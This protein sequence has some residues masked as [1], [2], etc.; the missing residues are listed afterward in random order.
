MDKKGVIKW[1]IATIIGGIFFVGS[2]AWEWSH[3]IH[4]SHYGSVE[5]ASGDRAI[6]KGFTLILIHDVLCN[7]IDAVKFG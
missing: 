5:L 4:G 1:M 7:W 2:Q 3:F 6:V